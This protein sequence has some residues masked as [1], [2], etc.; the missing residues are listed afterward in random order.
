MRT[1]SRQDAGDDRLWKSFG[2][3]AT[4]HRHGRNIIG[5]AVGFYLKVIVGFGSIS[6]VALGTSSEAAEE[7]HNGGRV[8]E[9]V[10]E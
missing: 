4:R 6:R 10:S 7:A 5:I 8:S 9:R 1:D 2:E 3:I